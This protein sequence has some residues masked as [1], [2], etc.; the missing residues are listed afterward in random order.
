LKKAKK[1]LGAN[2]SEK[3]II[4][5]NGCCYGKDD[6]PNKGDYI[7][8]CGEAFWTF[9]SGNKNLYIVLIEPFGYKAKEKNDQFYTEYSKVLNRFTYEFIEQ[10]C[11]KNG[12]I[13]WKAIL[14]FNSGK[15]KE[16]KEY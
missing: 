12:E 13:L 11:N 10:F 2:L 16:N 7:K 8:L 9:I 5:V 3:N 4:S 15:N 14:Q 1:I 6:N